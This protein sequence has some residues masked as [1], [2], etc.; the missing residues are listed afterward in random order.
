M[1]KCIN[2][3]RERLESSGR[4]LT[5][6]DEERAVI[7]KVA[8]EPPP[9]EFF[10]CTPCYRVVTDREMGA[11]LISGQLEIRLRVAGHPRA[12]EAAEAFYK[13]LISKSESK[14]VS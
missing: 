5:L 2:C 4:V 9:T 6:T 7:T 3:G 8:G 13:L 12:K 1:K 14:Q 11:R 10:Y